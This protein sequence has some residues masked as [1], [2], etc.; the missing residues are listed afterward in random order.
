MKNIL[1]KITDKTAVIGIMGLGYVGLP[2]GL[3][4]ANK[5]FQVIG[6]DVHMPTVDR[7]NKGVCHIENIVLHHDIS[8]LGKRLI[9][10]NKVADLHQSDIII[11][12]VPTPLLDDNT[13]DLSYIIQSVEQVI[14]YTTVGQLISLES[15]TYPGTTEEEV[16]SR[17]QSAGYKVG[18]DIFV[19]YSPERE[20]P[21]NSTY[22][23]GTI[24]KLCAGYS[25][26]CLQMATA[27]Y[28][29]VVDMVVPVS[30]LRTA[31][32]AKILENVHRA[33]NIGLVN[34]MKMVADKMD[35]DIY[36]VIN[37]AATKPFGFTPYYPGPGVGG[38]C[39]PID[40][41]YLTYKAKQYDVHTDFIELAG[42]VNTSM[43][44]WVVGKTVS[45]LDT[46]GISIANSNILILGLAYKPNVAD[47]R[48]T[49]SAE[50]LKLFLN[51]GV[52]VA[53]SDPYVPTFPKMR[54]Y[55]FDLHSVPITADT[56]QDY[57]AV[58]LATHHDNFDYDMI[59]QYAHLIIDTRG[60]YAS[61]SD[62]NI[63]QKVHKA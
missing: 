41:F 13:P 31:E 61:I 4:F 56:L 16:V 17:L 63:S 62:T 24:P 25:A 58:V 7:I 39:I 34:E 53:Y 5:G 37:A 45:A 11:I 60:V 23:T 2:L 6:F 36:E 33:V 46:K 57:D 10:T 52:K 44:A 15:T 51:M 35:I 3:S 20:D 49:P 48:E 43:P 26:N 27:L 50:L 1:N 14:P 8:L 21:G 29:S 30:S 42:K 9:A 40:P 59:L 12:C 54:K 38:H 18:T 32:M 28:Q 19:A 55:A 47:C 22:T